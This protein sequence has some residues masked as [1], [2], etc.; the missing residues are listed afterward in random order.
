ML[1]RLGATEQRV[2][3]VDVGFHKFKQLRRG[4]TAAAARRRRVGRLGRMATAERT[5][6]LSALLLGEAVVRTAISSTVGTVHLGRSGDGTGLLRVGLGAHQKPAGRSTVSMRA[7]RPTSSH[8]AH[9]PDVGMEDEA[10]ST[11]SAG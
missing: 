7:G 11:V 8:I 1:V 5:W 6:R 2:K 10:R 9:A 3:G 4:P